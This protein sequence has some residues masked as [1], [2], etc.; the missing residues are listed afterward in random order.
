MFITGPLNTG[1]ESFVTSEIIIQKDSIS[2]VVN[3][4]S[5]AK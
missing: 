2:M 3:N 4:F 1:W 5:K